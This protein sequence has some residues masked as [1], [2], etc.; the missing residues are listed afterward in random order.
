MLTPQRRTSGRQKG[1]P[2]R[3][4]ASAV[5]GMLTD[6]ASLLVARL[7]CMSIQRHWMMLDDSGH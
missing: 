1:D 5:A 3:A 2:D 6:P 7:K 4:L